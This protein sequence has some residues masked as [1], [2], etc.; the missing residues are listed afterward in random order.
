MKTPPD[1][2][3]GQLAERQAGCIARSQALEL[4]VS[5]NM[6]GH[7]LATQRWRRLHPGVYVLSGVPRS[8]MQEIWAAALAVGPGVAVTHETALLL[9]G[10]HR[11][12]LPRHPIKLTV[13]HG[14]HHRVSGAVVHQI[15]DLAEHHV[16][17][18]SGLRVTL[19]PRA[20]I[21]IAASTGRRRLADVLDEMIVA[22]RSSTTEVAVCLAEI[23]RPG[24]RGMAKVAQLLDSRGP[25][26]VP[27]HSE[28]ERRLFE[29][30]AAA[31]LPEPQRQLRLPGRGAI[32]GF[33]DAGYPDAKML[34]EADGRRWHTRIRDLRRDHQRDAEAIQAGWVTLRFVYEQIVAAP[35]DVAE[36]VAEVRRT[37]L[38]QLGRQAA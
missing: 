25:G 17:T 6:I 2:R 18:M 20:I 32:E 31:G 4:G 9:H 14:R 23:A 12:Q 7:R 36:T 15:D 24:K 29:T 34:I 30:L 13:P 5:D 3:I 27:P 21:D 35:D 10:V 26:T 8:W 37:R 16:T 19:P 22:R 1:A 38:A 28:L 33:A 11:T